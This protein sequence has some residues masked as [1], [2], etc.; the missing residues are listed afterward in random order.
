M[1]GCC[2]CHIFLAVSLCMPC[3]WPFLRWLYSRLARSLKAE[4][5]V[6]SLE[7]VRDF[8]NP[9]QGCVVFQSSKEFVLMAF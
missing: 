4:V 3:F 1:E 5:T 9:D 8:F 2:C 6:E 7:G